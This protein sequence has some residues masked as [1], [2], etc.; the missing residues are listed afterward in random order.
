MAAMIDVVSLS[1]GY[2]DESAADVTYSSGLWAAIKTLLGLG[3]AGLAVLRRRR[4]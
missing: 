2:F 4:T 1:L 3:V